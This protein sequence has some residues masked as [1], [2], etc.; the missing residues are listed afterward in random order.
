MAN[1]FSFAGTDMSTYGITLIGGNWPYASVGYHNAVNLPTKEG[2][3]SYV[4]AA[5]P[6]Q[7]TMECIATASSADALIQ[8]LQAFATAT[9]VETEGSIYIDGITSYYW[10]GRRVS[11]IEAEPLALNTIQFTIVWHLDSPGPKAAGT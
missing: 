5:V 1:S 8:N 6:Q 7:F 4:N 10:T 2:G 11:P 3:Y 9:P